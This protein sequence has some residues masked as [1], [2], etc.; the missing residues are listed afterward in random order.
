GD[1][2]YGDD[3]AMVDGKMSVFRPGNAPTTSQNIGYAD[4]LRHQYWHFYDTPLSGDGT[5]TKPAPASSALTEIPILRDGL[6]HGN[7]DVQSYDLVWLIHLV[8]DVHQPLHGVQ[9]FTKAQPD[10]DSGGG[11]V[12]LCS[13]PNCTYSLHSFWDGL[14]GT[15]LDVDASIELGQRLL[16]LP[17]P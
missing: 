7:Q 13:T 17:A 2:R 12:K 6:A 8:G 1:A 15:R 4:K 16:K 14:F 10:G 5:P 9:R 11:D 3:G